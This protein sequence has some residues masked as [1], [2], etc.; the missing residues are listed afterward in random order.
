MRFS[1]QLDPIWRSWRKKV[2]NGT[3]ENVHRDEGRD[4]VAWRMII[5]MHLHEGLFL[6][7]LEGR[8]KTRGFGG[9]VDREWESNSV[10]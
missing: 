6:K 9:G 1:R 7:W 4:Q 5:C 10:E 3:T 2:A 8:G